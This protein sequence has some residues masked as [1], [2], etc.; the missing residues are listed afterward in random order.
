VR[1]SSSDPTSKPIIDHALLDND[2]D[3][4]VLAEGCRVGHEVLMEGRGTKDV[5]FGPGQKPLL[6]QQI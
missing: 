6:I 4:A 5:I 1:L 2:L 3:M